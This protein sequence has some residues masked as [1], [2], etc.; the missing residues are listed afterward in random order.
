VL[1]KWLEYPEFLLRLMSRIF[2]L[3]LVLNGQP[4]CPMYFDG[5]LIN[6]IAYTPFFHICQ[7]QCLISACFY[8]V[9]SFG[10]G[11]MCVS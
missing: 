8:S 1:S 10:G 9:F 4:V 6:F 2:S 3:Y 5:Q 7:I 11:F